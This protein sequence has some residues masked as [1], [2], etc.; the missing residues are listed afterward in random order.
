MIAAIQEDTSSSP[1]PGQ[2]R[3][4]RKCLFQLLHNLMAVQVKQGFWLKEYVVDYQCFH[5]QPMVVLIYGGGAGGFDK[6]A[7]DM[8]TSW[9]LV[10]LQGTA[11]H[12]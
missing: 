5:V 3:I 11:S 4:S 6:S 12:T 10:S 1:P 8:K 7:S 2:L 9:M